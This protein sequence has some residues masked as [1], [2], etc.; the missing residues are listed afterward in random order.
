MEVI[1][2][3]TIIGRGGQL[4]ARQ[5]ALGAEQSQKKPNALDENRGKCG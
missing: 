5:V 1:T 2:S 4:S 3:F